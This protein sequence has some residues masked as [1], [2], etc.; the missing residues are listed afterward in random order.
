[1]ARNR[2][3]YQSKAVYAGPDKD[4]NNAFIDETGANN[5][6]QLKRVQSANYG[7]DI[8]RTDVN[9]FGKLAAIDR[10]ILESPTV[11]FDSSWYSCGWYN[12]DKIGLKI[13]QA[14][15]KA[16]LEGVLADVLENNAGERNYYVRVTADGEDMEAVK[17]GAKNTNT[18][19]AMGVKNSVIGI[20][21]GF[22]SN[23]TIEGAVGGFPT[24]SVTV[25]GLNINF[26]TG[27]T[28]GHI[29]AVH[30]ESG[31]A[32]T[33]KQYTLG[34]Y[35][36]DG[37]SSNSLSA[38][39]PGD[40]T[41][42]FPSHASSKGQGGADYSDLKVQS[43]N[44]A[45]DLA[46]EPLQKLGSRFAFSR[47]LTFPITT[48]MSVDANVGDLMS[49]NLADIINNNRDDELIVSLNSGS[50]DWMKVVMKNAKLDSQSF[51]QGI[52][53]NETVTLNWS[54]QIGSKTDSNNGLFL[55]GTAAA[56][57]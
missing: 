32:I 46:R 35:D 52:G 19:T 28:T 48:T 9:Q 31:T 26:I 11:N 3:I 47:E 41:L 5:P 55:S 2:V 17:N 8:A 16:S 56:N 7:F 44:C 12:E 1:M 18:T 27:T 51:S 24:A 21:N 57:G 43:F 40:V 37:S 39:K 42:T 38:I 4:S 33:D 53:D 10:I 34:N 13:N 22:L 23:Y 14:T 20:G 30:P 50:N 25:E 6:A 54:A 36:D 15:A 29:P 49:G 45:V